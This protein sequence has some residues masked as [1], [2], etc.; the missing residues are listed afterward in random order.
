[1]T[2][3]VIIVIMEIKK[4]SYAYS[5]AVIEVQTNKKI[6]EDEFVLLNNF[7]TNYSFRSKINEPKITQPLLSNIPVAKER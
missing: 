4:R 1:M 5:F 7:S 6:S 3:A 2:V